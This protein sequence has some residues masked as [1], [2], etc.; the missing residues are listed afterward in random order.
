MFRMPTKLVSGIFHYS[1]LPLFSVWLY[2]KKRYIIL[3]LQSN[4]Y[5]TN[6]WEKKTLIKVSEGESH[7]D[8]SCVSQSR[9]NGCWFWLR[10]IIERIWGRERIDLGQSLKT[11]DHFFPDSSCQMA[12]ICFLSLFPLSVRVELK[13]YW[14]IPNF[15]C[16]QICWNPFLFLFLPRRSQLKIC[17]SRGSE[18]NII[19]W[20]EKLVG[21]LMLIMAQ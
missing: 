1:Y 9:L 10:L 2:W 17:D 13:S 20:G 18:R 16:L 12:I 8:I 3:P 14:F 21:Y 19:F 6:C 7:T 5:E 11:L 15:W 4:I